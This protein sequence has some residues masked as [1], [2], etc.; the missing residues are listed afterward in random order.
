MPGLDQYS[1]LWTAAK[2]TWSRRAQAARPPL[3]SKLIFGG[4]KQVRTCTPESLA[5]AYV[6][7]EKN[8][9]S[10]PAVGGFTVTFRQEKR[11]V[12]SLGKLGFL[13]GMSLW[14]VMNGSGTWGSSFRLGD[15]MHTRRL[16]RTAESQHARR[17]A[18]HIPHALP[19]SSH[20]QASAWASLL[21]P[22]MTSRN[23]PVFSPKNPPE[24]PLTD[25]ISQGPQGVNSGG[26][27]NIR[28]FEYLRYPRQ[29][30]EARDQPDCQSRQLQPLEALALLVE[31]NG[32][33]S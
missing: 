9:R 26:L 22:W 1:A 30:A 4:D 5:N 3:K 6:K 15:R 28:I 31:T 21:S 29:I 12:T 24:D 33:S 20:H 10:A 14:R 8:K 25:T 7:T 32:S 27:G 18:L 17:R 11:Q 16:E 23:T 2:P 13:A 19:F